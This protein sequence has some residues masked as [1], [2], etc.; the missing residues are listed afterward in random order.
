MP[1]PTNALQACFSLG[2]AHAL[3]V[4]RGHSARVSIRDVKPG[5]FALSL[6]LTLPLL[7]APP[8]PWHQILASVNLTP[9]V[10]ILRAG[11]AADPEVRAHVESGGLLILE[12]ESPAA[13]LLGFRITPKRI[14]VTSI[15]DVHNP[16]LPI[17]WETPV[18]LFAT[19][20]PPS[21][22]VFATDRW[23]R[24]PLL[25]GLRIGAGAILWSA[26]PPG[27][28]GYERFPYVLQALA[29]LGFT[30]KY[31]SKDL[32]AFFDW[33]YRTRVD[34]DHFAELWRKSG[35][36]ALHV[37]AWHF[38][39]PDP[40]RDEY[41]RRLIT[42]CH[43][44]AILVYAWLELPHISEQFW[45]DHPEWREKTGL[46]QDA[47]L[48]WRKLMNLQNRDCF[49]AASRQVRDLLNRFDW[50]GV[51]L[52]ELYFES[53]EG[54]ANPARFTPLNDDVRRL[55]AAEHGADPA[56]VLRSRD[57]VR[58][59]RFLDFRAELARKMQQDWLGEI[60]SIRK[61]HLDVVL[62]HVDDRFDTRMRDLIG[63]D[64]ARV[65]PM[66]DSRDLT[67][68]IEDPATVWNLGP[69]RYD[70][71]AGRYA[72]L[73]ARKEKLAIDIN[74]VERYQ[75]VYPTKQQTGS[76][77]FRL[78]H[79]ASRAFPR[80]AVYFEN[81]ILPVDLGLLPSAAAVMNGTSSPKQYGIVS[82]PLLV[83][84][85]PWPVHDGTTAWLPAGSHTTSPGPPTALRLLDLNADLKSARAF[86]DGV[87]FT[88]SST[89]RAIAIF[90]K[91]VTLLIDGEPARS[92]ESTM[93]FLPRGTHTV[94]AR[95]A[96]SSLAEKNVSRMQTLPMLS[97]IK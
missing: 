89:S 41:L 31:R 26:A 37:A 84:G 27:P 60:E 80:V 11:A 38:N 10:R 97:R 47:H 5:R 67:F 45:S 63:A 88:Y 24:A 20:L 91:A 85:A 9:D 81:S 57:P 74:I 90:D 28:R 64:A 36:S 39:E 2:V 13:A 46:L 1:S 70:Q 93:N 30:P 73:T 35:I 33:S 79:T 83:D 12:S 55:F 92:P 53:L 18:D 68:L 62:T 23:T 8:D 76:E 19:E 7:A 49:S 6:L 17:I 69:D 3:S 58:L 72:P 52:A 95:I 44:R 4:Q 43:R 77:L 14:R 48:D 16:K 66:L 25:A 40:D 50:D 71:I 22:K 56:E 59:K 32:W 87:E 65:L 78:I 42:A 15:V 75:D 82:A 21:A 96:A 29:D 61:P 94:T 51:N 86:S 34:L 54:A